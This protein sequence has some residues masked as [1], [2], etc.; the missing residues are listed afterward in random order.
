MSFFRRAKPA[1]E[2]EKDDK[3]TP[4]AAQGRVSLVPD[5]ARSA[6]TAVVQQ[7]VRRQSAADTV[8]RLRDVAQ[9]R[10][11]HQASLEA[12]GT[13]L[14]TLIGKTMTT[15]QPHVVRKLCCS[16]S[17]AMMLT[18]M[19]QRTQ[20]TPP[21]RNLNRPSCAC[22]SRV[23]RALHVARWPQQASTR[24]HPSARDVLGLPLRPPRPRHR[25]W[26]RPLLRNHRYAACNACRMTVRACMQAHALSFVR[27]RYA[28]AQRTHT[29]AHTSLT[30]I[31]ST[32]TDEGA[33]NLYTWGNNSYGQ[34]AH[35]HTDAV[36]FPMPVRK[37]GVTVKQVSACERTARTHTC[38]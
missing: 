13:K 6:A 17:R 19:L 14:S 5:H 21:I 33:W 31:A 20:A 28:T 18:G 29:H 38:M 27:A 30:P 34:L 9:Q 2:E 23:R 15:V 36:E 8:A 24:R 26:R 1:A 37:L 7:R 11:E 25:R 16:R 35:G 22:F 3:A 12:E 4:S 10:K 32:A